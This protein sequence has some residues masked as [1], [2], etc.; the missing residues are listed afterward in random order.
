L[1]DPLQNLLLFVQ[2]AHP[3]WL[4][5]Q[6]QE[7]H[8]YCSANFDD[9]FLLC[10]LGNFHFEVPVCQKIYKYMALVVFNIL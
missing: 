8:V 10:C 4:P 6:K 5:P 2:M 3:R 9:F 7:G 1:D